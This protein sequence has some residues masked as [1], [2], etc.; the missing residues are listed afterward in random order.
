MCLEKHFRYLLYVVRHKYFVL[1]ECWR[2]GLV[3]RGVIHDWS[4]FLPSEWFPYA[5]FFYPY[6][7]PRQVRDATGYYKPTDTGDRAFDFAWHLHQKRNRHHWQWWV[8]PEDDGGE[9]VIAMREPYRTEMLCDWKGAGRAQGKPDTRAWYS[10][11]RSKMRLHPSTRLWIE[12]Q[13]NFYS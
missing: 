5:N 3:W 8:L 11:N 1:V 2:R 7:K 4:K 9:K 12:Q 6:G 10:S 13:L